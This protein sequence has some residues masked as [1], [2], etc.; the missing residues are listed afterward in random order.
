MKIKSGQ[1]KDYFQKAGKTVFCFLFYGSDLGAVNDCALQVLNFLKSQKT[2]VEDVILTSDSFK[3]NPTRLSEEV[4]SSSLFCSKKIIWIKNPSDSL[5]NELNDYLEKADENTPVL[6]VTS[7]SFNTKSKTVALINDSPNAVALGCYIQEGADLRATISEQL[8]K[9]GFLIEPEAVRFLCD[10]LGAD[11]GA[12]LSE[13]NK[14]KLYKGDDK[15]ITLSDAEACFAGS[16]V[17]SSDDLW[18]FVLTGQLDKAQKKMILLLEEG[19]SAVSII[20]VFLNKFQQLIRVQG[21]MANGMNTDE[22]IKKVP[23]FIPFKYANTWRQIVLSWSSAAVKEAFYR[24][25]EAEKNAKSGLPDQLLLKRFI[26]S[27]AQ[28]GKKFCKM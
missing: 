10:S 13:L 11:K 17:A 27:L 3:E 18:A 8:Q 14:L 25:I 4:A 7:D 20:R 21:L 24:T 19:A 1:L 2:P 15:R 22:A 9:D 16:A 26:G 23:P 5:L 28:A 6:I 12:T